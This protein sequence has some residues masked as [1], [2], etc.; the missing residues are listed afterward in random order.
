MALLTNLALRDGTL[1][2]QANNRALQHTAILHQM[3]HPY[4]VHPLDEDGVLQGE[5]APEGDRAI[6][7]ITK[8]NR[9]SELKSYPT[10]EPNQSRRRSMRL[11]M[12][13]H[14]GSEERAYTLTLFRRDEEACRHQVK[15]GDLPPGRQ[16][17]HT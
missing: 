2:L 5:Q 16:Q 6:A 15:D 1:V 10:P 12:Y 4:A 17:G 11:G 8:P 13:D 9:D 14:L 7:A 3:E